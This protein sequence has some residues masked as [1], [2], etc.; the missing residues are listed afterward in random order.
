MSWFRKH[1]LSDSSRDLLEGI[2]SFITVI[3]LF[4]A[5]LLA[6]LGAFCIGAFG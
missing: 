2:F 1:L 4:L 6:A 3:M 5:I